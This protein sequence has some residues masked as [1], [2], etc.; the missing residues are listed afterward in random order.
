M[1]PST[2]RVVVTNWRDLDHPETGGAEA[3]CHE[4]ATRLAARGHDVTLLC[5][6]VAGRPREEHRDGYRVVR[7]GGRYGVYAAA[8]AWLLLH[9]RTVD[10]VVDSQNGIPF[11]T[12]LALPRR[13]PVVML[14]HHVHQD[15]FAS[16]FPRP[17]AA[18]GRWLE[19]P[20]SRAVYGYRAVVAVSPSTRAEARRRL[21]LRGDVRVAPPGWAVE[22]RADHA[23]SAHPHVVCVGRLVPHKRTDLVVRAFPGVLAAHPDARLT[24]VGR[25]PER[26]ALVSLVEQLGLSTQVDL[27]DDLDDAA[28]D[29]VLAS[30]WLS[31]NASAGEG[32][33]LSVVEANALGVPVLAYR[34]PGLRDSVDDGRTGWL[35]DDDA[36]LAQEVADR[37]SELAT[38]DRA[39]R[40]AAA[41]REWADGFTWDAQTDTVEQVL[42]SEAVRLDLGPQDRRR[43]SD[44][45]VVVTVPD[46]LLPPDWTSRTRATDTWTTAEHGATAL[47]RAADVETAR[48]AVARLGIAE[49]A[50]DDGRVDV[51][52]AQTVDVMRL[53][54][55]R[56][57]VRG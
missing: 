23:R 18:L 14:L 44:A 37:L 50:V 1:S 22:R 13:T 27:L 34:R 32:W 15:Q 5:A 4:L 3:V 39:A 11:F 42:R 6:A 56:D 46:D 31:V 36:D 49:D 19:G 24:I 8:L 12:P 47:L 54:P 21:R 41:A 43:R 45:A 2:L 26:P 29:R 30:A 35:V 7:R 25:G 38:P 16:Y 28:R 9:R 57:A 20:V 51:R 40:Y 17:V 52:V 48:R 53:R 33:G 55:E 10:A